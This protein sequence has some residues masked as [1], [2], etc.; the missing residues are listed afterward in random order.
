MNIART[1][2]SPFAAAIWNCFV[3]AVLLSAI[4]VGITAAQPVQDTDKQVISKNVL[5][6]YSYG[7]GGKGIAVFDDGLIDT[8]SRGGLNT[9]NLFF[10]YLDLERHRTDP[11]YATR[12]SEELRKKYELHPIDAILT[13]Q[14]PALAWLL[15]DGKLIAPQ[16]PTVSVQAPAP[17][18]SEAGNRRFVSELVEFDVK[19]TLRNAFKLFP[20]TQRVVL[21]A[22]N[23]DADRRMAQDAAHSLKLLS[24]KIVVE[25]SVG[26]PYEQMIERIA[27]LPTNTIIL[28]LQ[29]N[30]DMN[31]RATTSYEVENEIVRRAN[32]PVFGLYDFNLN[33]GGI[34]GSI[35][36]VKRLGEETGEILLDLIN[37][38]RKLSEPV[39][40]VE[41]GS[42][43]MFSWKQ[44]KRWNGHH[45][46]LPAD[47]V[48]VD[49]TLSFWEQY[50][51]YAVGVALFITAESAL[52][53]ALL[54]GRRRYRNA[55][56]SLLDSDRKLR[57]ISSS[58]KDAILMIDHDGNT[59]FWNQAAEAIF[60]YSE[61]EVLGKDLHALLVPSK[62]HEKF[63]TSFK[64]FQ[65][66]G[67]GEAIGK[68]LRLTGLRKGGEEFPVELS[69]SAVRAENR[70]N[71]VGI[72]RDISKQTQL[73]D[74]LRHLSMT[75]EQSP[76]SI[77]IADLDA[78]I[79]YVNNAFVEGTGYSR[80]EAIGQNPR[81]LQSGRTPP[82]TYRSLWET[83]ARGH[84]WSGELYNKRKDG[85]EYIELAT[86]TPLRDEHGTIVKYV[87]IKEDI[88]ARKAAE[89]DA[90]HLAFFDHLTNLP[91]RRLLL[92]RL[93]KSLLASARNKKLGA[94]IYID[95]DNFKALNDT[96]GHDVGDQL[97][98]QVGMRLVSC[99]RAS[100]TVARFGGDEFVV[101]IEDLEE[102]LAASMSQA[103]VVGDKILQ[104]LGNPFQ[105]DNHS[106]NSS[107]S[108]GIAMF[109]G[110][111]GGSAEVLKQADIAMY[112]AKDAGRNA[113]RFFDEG[114]QQIVVAHAAIEAEV[115]HA[116]SS[117]QFL[118]HFQP[119]MDSQ[120]FIAGAE[121]LVRL[122]RPPSE[123]VGPDSF[124]PIAEK[125]SLILAI[126]D[127]VLNAACEQLARWSP[128]PKLGQLTLAVNVSAR[129]FAEANFVPSVMSA[130]TRSN[131][132]P[133]RL[134]LELT[135]SMLVGSYDAIVVKMTAL[136]T[137]GIRFALDD[138]GTG[139]S[140]LAYLNRLSLDQVKIDKSFVE[141]VPG[142][143]NACAIVR[144][145]IALSKTLNLKVV[146][147][148]VETAEQLAFLKDSGCG[149]YQGYLFG[150]PLPLDAFVA[151]VEAGTVSDF[152]TGTLSSESS[153]DL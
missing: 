20:G 32:A 131:A 8:L 74:K 107:A 149:L 85:T 117:N 46:D 133:R 56:K 45:S 76:A 4:G 72:V 49:R 41:V 86:I 71:A 13:V 17:S 77:V 101:M 106:H 129:Q 137:L 22:G 61:P 40:V 7:H 120:G 62:F 29:Y 121:A 90:L 78:H 113:V 23:S 135:E 99:V 112:S 9:N 5:L 73:E 144:T 94:L 31:D 125:S 19:G 65:E 140:S 2:M 114:M 119:K 139:Y 1:C 95:L 83:L 116:L 150:I 142:D 82:E 146:A 67:E 108:I 69:L 97:L 111:E 33:S 14:Q 87:A 11:H 152:N 75:V 15:G 124:I 34:G 103:A 43:P 151:L 123:F 115:H 35:V 141:G 105:L 47:T 48:Y 55:E 57:M 16:V 118:L 136:R 145:I 102:T 130:L 66:T 58:S 81:I 25:S 132:N 153:S 127:W 50:G 92:D 26:L 24:D 52:I 37:G 42:R 21:I 109:S 128:D 88:T 6:L 79:E 36:S 44:I 100:D 28:F 148:G 12:L 143:S 27:T 138:F 68:T 89:A 53:V 93:E 98:R 96:A 64:R 63:R 80:E 91:N 18:L 54:I 134:I 38:N 104:S 147:E 60:G 10:E 126:G 122:H 39:T 30:R 70:W 51:S 84:T 110:N 3:H 59:I